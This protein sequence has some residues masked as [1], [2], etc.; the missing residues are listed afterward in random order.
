[1]N[2]EPAQQPNDASKTRRWIAATALV[3]AI[4]AWWAAP[5]TIQAGDAGEFA[6]VMLR[7]GVPHPSGYPWMRLLGLPARALA[8]LGITPALAAALPCAVAAIAGWCWIAASTARLV[9]PAFAA[10]ATLFV[11]LAHVVVEHSIDAEVWGPLVVVIAAAWHAALRWRGRPFAAGALWGL[12]L[13][14]HLTALWLMPLFAVAAWP[15]Q[16]PN[17]RA[18]GSAAARAA[19]GTAAGLAPYLTLAV[20]SDGAWQWGRT[21][22]VDGLVDHVLR[23]DFG[24]FSLSLHDAEPRWLDQLARVGASLSEALTAGLTD[25]A[26]VAPIIIIAIA[27][28]AWRFLAP[29]HRPAAIA[30]TLAFLAAALAFPIASDIDPRSPFA[31][32]I[33][34]RFDIMPLALLIPAIATATAVCVRALPRR[35][36]LVGM[37]GAALL[38][39]QVSHTAQRGVPADDDGVETYA[40]DLLGTA[41]PGVR[42]FVLGTNDHRTFPVLFAQE[43]LGVAP[44]VVYIDAQL[45]AHPWYRERLSTRAPELD[46][47]I[48]KPIRMVTKLWT[49]PDGH[50]IPIYLAND[51]SAPSAALGRT[52]EGVL[53]RIQPAGQAVDPRTIVERHLAAMT[54]WVGPPRHAISPF[55][56]DLSARYTETTASLV[57]ALMR[58]G[59]PELAQRVSAAAPRTD[60]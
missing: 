24:T 16:R 27:A 20:A 42:A 53:W 11:A 29:V 31:V 49:E 36:P 17:I 26:V 32:W 48:D 1:M 23:R 34:E 45:L 15:R 35:G 25:G 12:G 3:L 40:R 28:A 18:L 58:G 30:A 4:V 51:F 57:E 55:S 43:V 54:R 44:E 56:R 60:P 37:L 10:F 2:G 38:A 39:A 7:G 41:G 46:I 33:L 59:Q 6:T 47:T 21:D 50:A 19:C 5:R 14:H 22:T 13:S 9:T 8:T 52:P